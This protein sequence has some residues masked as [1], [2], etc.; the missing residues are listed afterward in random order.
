MADGN[1]VIC[2]IA[3]RAVGVRELFDLCDLLNYPSGRGNCLQF[4]FA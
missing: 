1:G 3:A 2:A 4:G